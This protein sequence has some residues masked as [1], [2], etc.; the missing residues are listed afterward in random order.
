MFFPSTKGTTSKLGYTWSLSK[1]PHRTQEFLGFASENPPKTSTSHFWHSG[2]LLGGNFPWGMAFLAHG[3]PQK[4]M[5]IICSVVWT[6]PSETYEYVSWENHIPNIWK[7]EN[8]QTTNQ[9]MY[10]YLYTCHVFIY[11][12]NGCG[13]YI[14]YFGVLHIRPGAPRKVMQIVS[15]PYQ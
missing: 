5:Y 3:I 4:S 1:T 2:K 13:N 8:F 14:L 12:S 15:I 7:N 10:N 6:Y 9:V 11:M